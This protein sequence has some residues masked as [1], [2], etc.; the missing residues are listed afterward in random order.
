MAFPGHGDEVTQFG[1][2]HGRSLAVVPAAV[3]MA[4]L[5][6]AGAAGRGAR[7]ELVGARPRR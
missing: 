7:G 6:R 3:R 2:S 5:I 1:K 4:G